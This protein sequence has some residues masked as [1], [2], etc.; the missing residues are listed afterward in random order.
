[1]SSMES[2]Q[3]NVPVLGQLQNP[4]HASL[5][6]RCMQRYGTPDSFC[7]ALKWLAYRLTNAVK[8][9]LSC[10]G[11]CSSDWQKLNKSC[12]TELTFQI[13]ALGHKGP[14][15]YEA[16]KHLE[17]IVSVTLS[18]LFIAYN[19]RKGPEDREMGKIYVNA[20]ID[21]A[22]NVIGFLQAMPQL[23]AQA[24][25][26]L[27]QI[28]QICGFQVTPQAVAL[29]QGLL[30]HLPL[31]LRV[32]QRNI[33]LMKQLPDIFEGKVN[34]Q[35]L[36]DQVMQDPE[37]LKLIPVMQ[38]ATPQSPLGQMLAGLQLGRP[39]ANPEMQG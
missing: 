22:P 18:T 19:N 3:R 15:P 21:I 1:M 13:Q 11:C 10:F 39:P 24:L 16:R 20:G 23:S 25:T 31:I 32:A 28:E 38:L 4:N 27:P 35:A 34:P 8:A 26:A 2:V 29:M 33:G 36:M 5:A 17:K 7:G 37:A 14:L 30:P 6:D 9:A 12:V